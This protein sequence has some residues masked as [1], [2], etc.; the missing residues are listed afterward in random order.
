MSDGNKRMYSH[1]PADLWNDFLTHQLRVLLYAEPL[2]KLTL[3]DEHRA[4]ELRHY[5]SLSLALKLFDSII[6]HTGLEQEIDHN[7]ALQIL[8]PLLEAMDQAAGLEV[9]RTRELQMAERV[10]AVLRNDEDGQRPFKITYTDFDKNQVVERVLSVRLVEE[11]YHTDGRIILRLSNELTNLL[12]NALSTD[13]EDAQAAAEAIVQSQLARGRLHEAVN[14]ARQARFHSMRLKEKIER[15]LIDTRRDLSRVDWS[16]DVPHVL[17][18]SI[19]HLKLRCKVEQNIAR[20]ARERRE[21]LS[22]ESEEIGHLAEIIALV[23][24]CRQRHMELQQHLLRARLTFLDE[25]ERQAFTLL[26]QT[27]LPHLLSDVLEPLLQAPRVLAEHAIVD[28]LPFCLGVR[29]PRVFSLAHAI[30]RQ[31][32]PRR[33]PRPDS[34]PEEPRELVSVSN[35]QPYYSPEHTHRAKTYLQAI[36]KPVRLHELLQ[37]ALHADEAQQTVELLAFLV[38]RQF[39]PEEKNEYTFDVFKTDGEQF[40]LGHLTGDNPLL[41]PQEDSHV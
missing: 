30:Q 10:L 21:A 22:L 17:S 19:E 14:S 3:R 40:S 4:A 26:M 15:I 25:Q 8:L 20:S 13:I 27:S 23:E 34:V 41:C 38:L 11:R 18:E 9:N 28:M 33:E 31:L 32:Q 29:I 37:R 39:D 1:T 35:D 16:K 2:L 7:T 36:E 24:D 6:E 5:D 12:L